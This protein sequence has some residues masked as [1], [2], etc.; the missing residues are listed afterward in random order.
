MQ[1]PAPGWY[2]DPLSPQALI[3][4]WDGS[5]WTSD[6]RAVAPEQQPLAGISQPGAQ[7]QEPVAHQPPRGV[8]ACPDCGGAM[9]L[10]A[11]ACVHCGRPADAGGYGQPTPP[12]PS[13]TRPDA[14]AAPMSAGPVPAGPVPAGPAAAAP[15]PKGSGVLASL[16]RDTRALAVLIAGVCACVLSYLAYS[17]PAITIFVLS[18]VAILATFLLARGAKEHALKRRLPKSWMIPVATLLAAASIV[19]LALGIYYFVRYQIL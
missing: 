2:P 9:S 16:T 5:Q 12:P 17:R 4:R 13:V 10:S 19:L 8:I 7:Q 14:A 1:N 6:V 11:P 18:A 15:A 3:R